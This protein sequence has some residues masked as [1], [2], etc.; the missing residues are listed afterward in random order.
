MFNILIITNT[1]NNLSKS[2][3]IWKYTPTELNEI[4]SFY[5]SLGYYDIERIK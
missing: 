4:A 2:L 1:K 3:D 5:D